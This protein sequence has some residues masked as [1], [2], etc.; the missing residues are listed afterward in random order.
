MPP[1]FELKNVSKR[2][3]ANQYPV[4]D[5]INLVIYD[6]KI[7]ALMGKSGCGKS[8]LARILMALENF[9]SGEILFQGK[10][11]NSIP[12]KEFRKKNQV[13]FQ[14]PYLSVNPCFTIRKIL[15]EP[16]LINKKPGHKNEFK[17]K[18]DHLLELLEI[19]ASFLNRYPSELS[20]GQLQRIVLARALT[21]DPEFIVLDEPF[22]SLDEIMATRLIRCFKNIFSQLEIGV[23]FISHHLNHVKFLADYVAIMEKGRIIDQKKQP[24]NFTD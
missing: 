5:N 4:L 22:S 16:L 21:L 23:L 10:T 7:N 3:P 6:K 12:I 18:I 14:D 1:R 13:M 8:T 11:M 2:Y 9:D 20:G 24:S 15:W 17:D 19:P